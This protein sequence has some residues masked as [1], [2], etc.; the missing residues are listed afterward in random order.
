MNND[1]KERDAAWRSFIKSSV[2][3]T[4]ERVLSKQL[5]D[6][7]W[8]ASRKHR[9]L[10]IADELDGVEHHHN[11]FGGCRLCDYIEQIRKEAEDEK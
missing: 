9:E 6:A 2:P 3:F 4:E 11:A 7:G 5:F 8:N 10:Q 1:Q